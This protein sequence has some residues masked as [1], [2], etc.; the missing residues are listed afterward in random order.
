[1]TAETLKRPFGGTR[2][3]PQLLKAYESMIPEFLVDAG[4][5]ETSN[6]SDGSASKRMRSDDNDVNDVTNSTL[7]SSF[8]DDGPPQDNESMFDAPDG[9]LQFNDGPSMDDG[10]SNFEMQTSGHDDDEARQA[11]GEVAEVSESSNSV[12]PTGEVDARSGWSKRTTKMIHVL[13][14]QFEEAASEDGTLD[15]LE[16][17]GSD[18]NRKTAATTFFELLVLKSA[19]FID[20]VQPRPF[21]TISISKTVEFLAA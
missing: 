19:N 21:E 8:A 17:L 12:V 11:F 20:V 2:L 14:R 5:A 16:I 3:A 18:S 1:M 6:E 7:F 15:F 10:V 9:D 4:D 13:N